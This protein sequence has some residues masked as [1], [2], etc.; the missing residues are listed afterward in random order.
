M[1]GKF[2]IYVELLP[3]VEQAQAY[4]LINFEYGLTEDGSEP[5]CGPTIRMMELGIIPTAEN[6]DIHSDNS[7]YWVENSGLSPAS[8]APRPRAR[9]SARQMRLQRS[10][11]A[12]KS[13]AHGLQHEPCHARAVSRFRG[14]MRVVA[15]QMGERTCLKS[16]RV[17]SMRTGRACRSVSND[18]SVCD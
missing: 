15:R 2:S 16:M 14:A 6:M 7:D 9:R 5:V 18:V 3:Y 10:G 13:F 17:C 4:D 1:P 12:M 8:P 11:R